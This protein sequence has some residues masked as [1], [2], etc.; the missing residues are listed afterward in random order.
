MELKEIFEKRKMYF[1]EYRKYARE[2]KKIVAKKVGCRVYVFGS[3]LSGD[4]SIGL[5]DIDI[6]IV[7]EEFRDRRKKIR[8]S[9]LVMGKIF[10]HPIRVPRINP[11]TME[12][13]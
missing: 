2:I 6:A 12:V 3:I 5:S 1:K 8:D 10:R 11:K 7:S 13:L 9:R 4:Y